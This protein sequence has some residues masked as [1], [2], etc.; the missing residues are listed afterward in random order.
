MQL[1]PE[2]TGRCLHLLGVG[3]G[4]SGIGWIDSATHVRFTPN[5]D[6]DS[7]NAALRGPCIEV[8]KSTY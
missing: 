7:S 5:S 2:G 8:M 1:Q 3:L 6:I 4:N